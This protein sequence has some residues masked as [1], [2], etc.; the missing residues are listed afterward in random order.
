ML[1]SIVSLHAEKPVWRSHWLLMF[2]FSTSLLIL[3]RLAT[4]ATTSDRLEKT[5]QPS[6]SRTLL[7]SESGRC[8]PWLL[9]PISVVHLV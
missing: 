8:S 4:T 7:P 3:L 2:S 1:A 9:L 5:P 6:R